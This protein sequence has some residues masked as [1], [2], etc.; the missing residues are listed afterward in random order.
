[1]DNATFAAEAAFEAHHWWFVGRR[2]LFS[3][4][5]ERLGLSRNAAVLD[6]GT[7][8]GTNLRMLRAM[9]FVDVTGL[10]QSE[11]AIRFCA[12]KGLGRVQRGDVCSLPFSDNSFDLVLATDVLEHV[13]ADTVATA[14]VRRVV[15]P[16]G[17]V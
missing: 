16:Q 2:V 3:Q 14:E 15:R 5:I 7:S 12:E 8:T 4:I 11:E 13:S 1:L 6:V 10:D 9:G 17:Y